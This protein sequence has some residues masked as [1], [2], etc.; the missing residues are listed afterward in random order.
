MDPNGDGYTSATSN[1]F[2][3]NDQ[4]ESEIPYTPL[5]VPSVEPTSDLGRGPDCGFTDIVDSGDPVFSYFD[6]NDNLLFRF[7]LGKASSNSKGYSI[8]IDTDQKFGFS[9]SNADPNAV[10]GNPGF[11]IEIALRTNFGVSLYDVDGN[12]SPTLQIT[13]SYD[14]YVQKSVALTTNCGDADYFYDF[15]LPFSIITTHFPSITT[16]TPLRM[17]AVTSMDP[18]AAIGNN[19]ISDAGGIDDEAAGF[20]YDNIFTYIIDNFYPTSVTGIEGG[21]PAARTSCPTITGNI[22]VSSSSISG[23]S[24]EAS[25]TL[26]E[27]F[28]N[29][30]TFGTTIVNAGAWTLS[31]NLNLSAG[32][33]ITAAATAPEKSESYDNCSSITV[34]AACSEEVAIN[35]TNTNGKNVNG[36]GTPGAT[37]RVYQNGVLLTPNPPSNAIVNETGEFCWKDN[38]NSASC[39]SGPNTLS[40]AY[41]V[42]QQASGNCESSGVFLCIGTTTSTP[43]PVIT[44]DPIL[45]TSSSISGTSVSGAFIILYANDVQIGTTTA[46]GTVWTVSGLTLSYGQVITAKAIAGSNCLSNASASKT[47]T[48][49]SAAPI[50][51]GTYCTATVVSSVSGSSSEAEGTLIE[52]LAGA[53][54][55]GTAITNSN[56]GWTVTGLSL[57]PGTVVTAK[58]TAPGKLPSASSNSVTIGSQTS[59]SGL[60]VNSPVTEGD[61]SV[62][63]TL[64]GSGTVKVYIDGGLLGTATVVGS[65]W[66]LSGLA[67]FDLYAGA[68]VYATITSASDCESES[69]VAVM[70]QCTA[71]L[72]G[73]IVSPASSSICEGET[74]TVTVSSSESGVIY[75]LYNGSAGTGSSVLGTGSDIVLTSSPLTS[76]ASI[77]VRAMKISV[78]SCTSTLTNTHTAS[79]TPLIFS[80]TLTP[81][82]STSLCGPGDP[83]TIIGSEPAGGSG[84]FGYQWQESSDNLTFNDIDAAI[85]KDYDPLSIAGTTYYRRIV[86][87]G[88]CSSVSN[89]IAFAVQPAVLNNT[90]AIAGSSTFCVNGDP[91]EIDG[92]LPTAGSGI[93]SYTWQS[94]SGD[95]SFSDISGATSQNYDPPSISATTFYRRLVSSGACTDFPSNV[96]TFSVATLAHTE[97]TASSSSLEA[98]GSST[99][100]ITVQLQDASGTITSSGCLPV[101]FT[102]RGTLSGVIDNGDGTYTATLTSSTA[103]SIALITG[104]LNG[105]NISDTETVAF[106][107][108]PVSASGTT[109]SSSLSTLSAD[110]TSTSVITVQLK[111]VNGNNVTEGGRAITLSTTS[112]VLSEI[113]DNGNGTY[114]ATLTSSTVPGTAVVTGTL[115]GEIIGD[116]EEITFS[117]LVTNISTLAIQLPADGTSN[118]VV[119][120]TV[121][122]IDN[123]GIPG[124]LVQFNTTAGTLS[125]VTDHGDGTYTVTLTSSNAV[126]VASVSFSLNGVPNENTVEITFTEI[127]QD[128]LIFIPEGFSPDGDG[129]N[130]FFVIQGAEEY[131]VSLSVYNRWGNR[132]YETKEYENDWNGFANQGTVS[133]EKLPD[134]TYYYIVNLNNGKKPFVRHITIKRK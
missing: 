3:F 9:G 92:S 103:T 66:T 10:S 85:S 33:I 54:S 126:T 98:N 70:V 12:T 77:S 107:P 20:N 32:D 44:T 51:Y 71:P 25:G 134:G 15:Y 111:D 29:G 22:T 21:F 4:F 129:K 52:V 8:L 65:T 34:A 104:T 19:A 119:T 14:N 42:T 37:I 115:E 127:I 43:A 11:E 86:T 62:S 5:V 64:S 108:G 16:S 82:V 48:T 13:L 97:I 116:S 67:S 93:Y 30:V 46:A 94:S 59:N 24:A 88:S 58:A 31:G 90:I 101:L 124:M 80:N 47:V 38:G 112:G 68:S 99:S 53:T 18:S 79:V 45:T 132:V 83:D 74:T 60:T 41:K 117:T 102:N 121:K 75:Q 2:V 35:A 72:T 36:T 78:V 1:G 110:G 113:V 87:S 123:K 49:N 6:A 76:S 106:V 69:S 56:G 81:P 105:R 95:L 118:T 131:V 23:T 63:G 50:I 84:T 55:A 122:D 109:I 125:L 89:S 39:D 28:K 130:D 40:G 57:S 61:A 73:L 91:R 96:V 27:V 17:A 26:I 100:T 133:G 7:R 128:P 120:V 114:S